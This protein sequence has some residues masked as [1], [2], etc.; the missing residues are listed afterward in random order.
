METQHEYVLKH[1]EERKITSIQ[2]WFTDV[3]GFS[4][5]FSIAPAE[6]ETALLEGMTFDGSSIDGFSRVHESDMLLVPDPKSYQ[7]LP[8]SKDDQPVA[9][10]ICD[11]TNLDKSP[12]EGCPRQTLKRSLQAAQEKGYKFFAAPE[13]EY[14]YLKNNEINPEE[15]PDNFLDSGS[16]F[17]LGL[18]EQ[19]TK[20]RSLSVYALEEM[21]IPVEHAQHEDAPGQH[22]IDLRYSD[23]LSMADS[24]MTARAV[25]KSIALRYGVFASFMPKLLSDIQGSGMHT[26]FSLFEGEQNAFYDPGSQYHLSD[27]AKYFI[28]GVLYHARQI[29]AVTNQWV[30][31]YKR[32]APGFEAPSYV[33]W[34]RHNRSALI[35][36]PSAKLPEST[37]IEYRACDSACNPYLAFAA[38]LAAGLDGIENKYDLT[39]ELSSDKLYGDY[40]EAPGLAADLLPDNLGSALD[41]ME[42]SSLLKHALGEHVFEWFLLNKRQDWRE[43]QKHISHYEIK[44]YLSKL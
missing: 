3:L 2:L 22:E 31:S 4:K 43:Y 18:F 27:T 23:A 42:K 5:G 12:F 8:D 16:Y 17:D 39:Q 15:I 11:V 41:E 13:I 20:L 30:N 37:R 7:L 35:R 24:I 1:V 9:R 44:N 25:I 36:I 6:L 38:I 32:L 33:S 40:N 26:H 29:T 19:G 34:A 10:M 14:F 28:S 21:G